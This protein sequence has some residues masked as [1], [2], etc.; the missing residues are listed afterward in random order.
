MRPVHAITRKARYSLIDR[1]RSLDLRERL[2]PSFLIIG[3]QKCGTSSLFHYLSQHPQFDSPIKKEI[4][5]FDFKYGKGEQWY[6]RHFP[7]KKNTNDTIT[8][9]ATPFYLLHRYAPNR[10]WD[11]DKKIKIIVCLRNPIDRAYSEYQMYVRSNKIEVSFEDW[12]KELI[13][14]QPKKQD[15]NNKSIKFKSLLLRGL[16]AQQLTNWFRIFER[17]H[18]ILINSTIFFSNP[19]NTLNSVCDFLGIDRFT[20]FDFKPINTGDYSS[21]SP[22]CKHILDEYYR[23]P[24]RDL[25]ELTSSDFDFS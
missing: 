24:N 17:R 7:I 1:F 18:F 5:Y 20:K 6:L 16:Y 11:F 3:A 22:S 21:M 14:Y 9:E 15:W 13:N 19:Q 8:G 2:K 25:V 10:V 23:K 12:V 4:H